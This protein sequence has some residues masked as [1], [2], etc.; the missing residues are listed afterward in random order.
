MEKIL[1]GLPMVVVYIDNMLITGRSKEEHL[2]NLAKVLD[3][4]SEYGL[5]LKKQKC[6]FLRDSV[7]YLGYVID[8]DGLHATPAKVEAIVN[9]PSPKNV[10][11]LR[12][13]LGLVN[14]YGKFIKNLSTKLA[15]Q[16]FEYFLTMCTPIP[17][18]F[19]L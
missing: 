9:A 17:N 13:F 4:L 6:F 3:R 12:S 11:E 7:E 15:F 10:T 2:Q 1:Q 8:C 18:C 5:K 14:Y 19:L 16:L